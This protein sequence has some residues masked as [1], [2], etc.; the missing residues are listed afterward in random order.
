M[1][2]TE[3]ILEKLFQAPAPVKKD[4]LQIVISDMHSGS[5]YALF[6]PGEW[7]GKNTSHTASPA[8]KEIREHF[9]KFADEVLKERQGKRIR[10][11]HNGDA[12]DGDHHN[13][14]DVCTVL[15]LEQADIHIELM[16]E[17]QKR[18]DWQAGD[19]LYYTRGTDV[20]VNE[21]EN[22]IGRE[23]N[24]VSS[25]DF[26]SWNSLK[27]ESNGIQ[28]WFTHH[29]PAAGSGANEGNSMRNWLRGI[30][31]DALKD[32][33]RIPDIIYSGHVHNPTYSVFS[34]RQGMVFRNMHGIITPSWQLKTTYAWM[35][36]PVSKNKI[37]GVYQTIKA[38]GTI[39]VPSFCIM[40]TD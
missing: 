39:S 24:A 17:L 37:G 16:A 7:R 3:T 10:L 25:G 20:H 30:Y 35:K 6:V 8:Q 14:G 40:V 38:D 31:F 36:A 9:C 11:V 33:T 26:Y 5:N 2:S 23:L 4:I 32:G 21:F 12:I 15:P 13:S 34:H 18:I 19:E 29:G 28:S 1:L 27:L 22:Y